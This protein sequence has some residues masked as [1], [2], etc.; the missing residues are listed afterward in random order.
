MRARIAVVHPGLVAG[1]GSEAAALGAVRALQDDYAVTLITTGRPDL[2]ALNGKYGAG[3]DPG[4]LETRLA[5]V[6]PGTRR[7]FDALR[8]FP[9]AR[10]CRRHAREFDL[11]ISAYNVMDFGRPGVQMIADL[12]FDDGLRREADFPGGAGEP[13]FHRPSRGRSLYLRLARA[14]A[15]DREAGWRMN[16]TLANSRWV[17]RRLRDRLGLDSEVVYPP[18]AGAFPAVPWSEREDGFVA[19]GRLVP[20]K[21]FDLIVAVLAEVRKTRAVHLHIVGRRGRGAHGRTIEALVRRHGDW[22]RFEGEMYGPELA[23]F[24]ARHKYGISGRRAEPF[25]IAVA[26]MVKAGLVVW[27]PDCGGQVEI[28]DHPDLTYSGRDHAAA[29]IGR[30]LSD[31]AA[32]AGLRRH[33]EA[34]AGAFSAARFASEMKAVVEGALEGRSSGAV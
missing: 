30:V 4:R 12:S 29:L 22:V 33:L 31:A 17:A 24:L 20:E 3:I 25:G 27:V 19:V 34:R 13:A 11:M 18:V 15:G 8:G 32:E 26:E 16:R 5:A 9:L 6:P 7:R 10:Y 23:A 2:A 28:V 1:G 14:L 21:R